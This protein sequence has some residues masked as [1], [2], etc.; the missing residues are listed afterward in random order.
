[1]NNTIECF[2]IHEQYGSSELRFATRE[3][4]T[5]QLNEMID[6]AE[7]QSQE[8]FEITVHNYNTPTKE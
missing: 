2:Y 3:E 5:Q 1:M 8:W 4:F 6:K 7:R